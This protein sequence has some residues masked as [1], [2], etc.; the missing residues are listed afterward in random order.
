MGRQRDLLPNTCDILAWPGTLWT[1]VCMEMP[2]AVSHVGLGCGA[3]RLGAASMGRV[4]AD[5]TSSESRSGGEPRW[6]GA[7]VWV[8][9][10]ETP[11]MRPQAAGGL[12]HTVSL[13]SPAC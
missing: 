8:W 6:V 5:S 3:P 7:S 13:D 9:G 10:Q 12:L 1:V 4:G 11:R 2:D